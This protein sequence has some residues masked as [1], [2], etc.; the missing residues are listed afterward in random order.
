MPFTLICDCGHCFNADDR[1]AG[2]ELACP[3]CGEP[4]L[5]PKPEVTPRAYFSNLISSSAPAATTEPIR[6]SQPPS[7]NKDK[8]QERTKPT[9]QPASPQISHQSDAHKIKTIGIAL[10]GTLMVVIVLGIVLVLFSSDNTNQPQASRPTQSLNRVEPN[11]ELSSQNIPASSG[12][13]VPQNV[14]P[15]GVETGSTIDPKVAEPNV[16]I[17]TS[18]QSDP[19]E[20]TIGG[21]MILPDPSVVTP[22]ASN[23][24]KPIGEDPKEY[25]AAIQLKAG[26]STAMNWQPNRNSGDS[27]WLINQPEIRLFGKLPRVRTPSFNITGATHTENRNYPSKFPD[28]WQVW[29][30]PYSKVEALRPGRIH[31]LVDQNGNL[32]REYSPASNRENSSVFKFKLDPKYHGMWLNDL[33]YIY[34]DESENTTRKYEFEVRHQFQGVVAHDRLFS[35]TSSRWGFRWH[36]VRYFVVDDYFYIALISAHEKDRAYNFGRMFSDSIRLKP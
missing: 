35:Q 11:V 13:S 15:M 36:Y 29:S 32:V 4:V 19:S 34:G 14:Q 31:V 17:S 1:Y 18:N 24:W 33:F 30:S 23:K 20:Q 27:A 22:V 8:K 7:F 21:M 9:T 25:Y 5:V 12:V 26:G 6:Q 2:I 3:K 16:S 28:T 10:G